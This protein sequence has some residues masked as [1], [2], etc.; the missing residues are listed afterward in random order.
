MHFSE[1]DLRQALRPKDPGD[2]LTQRVMARIHQGEAKATA[3]PERKRLF[4]RL[5]PLRLRPALAG[6]MAAVILV[7]G[8]WLGLA[9][10]KHTQELARGER[11]KQQ[12]I[13]ALRITNAKLNQ[14]FERVKASQI[15]E[16]KIKGEHL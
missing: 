3:L 12:A 14:V 2:A 9:Q 7:A 8:G 13:L 1:D 15:R 10:Y 5:W 11:A 16:A 6:A 4:P